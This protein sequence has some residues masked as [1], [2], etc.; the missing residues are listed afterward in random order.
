MTLLHAFFV[1]AVAS[2]TLIAAVSDWRTRKLP[3][4]LTVSAFVAALVFHVVTGGLAG[5]QLSLFGFAA[6]FGFLLV[7]WLV[8]GSG[9]GDVK[10]MGALG[11]WLGP[12]LTLQVFL[13]SAVAI[14]AL[15]VCD[16]LLAFVGHGLHKV[17]RHYLASPHG[18]P[19]GGEGT[20]EQRRRFR[21]LPYA[22]PVAL[23]T[24]LVL[25]AAWI[26]ARLPV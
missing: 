4:W 7:L 5:L 10:L 1:L 23:S 6:G 11:A 15:T 3:N 16:L 22:I 21:V 13:V 12:M 24:W 8:G 9:G 25:G 17:Q 20:V 14:A 2:F 18:L 26:T 19:K